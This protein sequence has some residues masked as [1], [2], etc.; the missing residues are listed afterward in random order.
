[1]IEVTN[2]K[3]PGWQ[4]VV[5]DLSAPLPDDRVFL[6]RLLSTL[7]LVSN[8]RQG[9]LMLL[10]SAP[11]GGDQTGVEVRPAQV[12]PFSTDVVDAQGRLTQPSD[13]LVDPARVDSSSIERSKDVLAAARAAATT[14]QLQVFSLEEGQFYDANA[15][16]QYVIAVPVASGLPHESPVLPPRAVVTLIVESRSRQ[17]LQSVLALLEVLCGYVFTHE[18]QQSLRRTRQASAALDLA[19]RLIAAM[20][21]TVGFKASTIQ[22]VNDLC[23]QLSVDRVAMG[24][25]VGSPAKWPGRRVGEEAGSGAATG[26]GSRAIH[27]K[28]LSDTEHIDRRMEMCRKIEAAMEEC[29]DQQQP[30]LFPPPPAAGIGS[31]PSLSQA[32]VHA[33][34][35]LA[36]NDANIRAASFPLRVV[37]AGGERI[38]GVI[39]LES[40]GQARIDP[41]LAEL[42]QA[43]L[44]LVAPVIAVRASDDRNLALR[45]LDA[46][47]RSAAWAVGPRHTVW[48]VAGIALMLATAVLFL[49]RTT[50]RV[51]APMEMKAQ[52]HRV[53]A[54]PVNG[55]IASIPDGIQ[56]GAR[57]SK[58]QVLLQMDTRELALSLLEARAQQAQYDKQADEALKKGDAAAAG[59]S[60]AR[61]EQSRARGDLLQLQINR[62]T[63]TSPIDGT[64][65]SGDVKDRLGSTLKLGDTI[66]EVADLGTM[67]VKARVDD[68]DISFVRIGQTGE[69][70]PK[71]NPSLKVP[72]TVTQITPLAQA[73]EGSNSFEVRCALGPTGGGGGVSQTW[74][75]PGLEGQAKLNTERR[76][77]AWILSRRVMDQL[78]VWLW[79]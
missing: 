79:W 52:L 1:M 73:G 71:A 4:R 35:E 14:K 33:H 50:Y 32:I 3:S 25:V 75:L 41:A 76:S 11:S 27:L 2:I 72:I 26:A 8:A 58:G 65:I 44:D 37:D 61:G 53:I 66:F 46:A 43:T 19:A 57:V 70:S 42:V 15:N 49:G 74:F 77:F 36:K 40:S 54:A 48:K 28:A 17:A 47:H 21:A 18:A 20:N 55:L 31:D 10:A 23:R 78:R 59:Q 56:A 22:L 13:V 34:R 39:T 69:I 16:G 63:I 38:A 64:I 29:L 62:S 67:V 5:S 6:L 12:W 51:S 30:V 68:R 60:Q 24:W 45:T 7:G 9:V